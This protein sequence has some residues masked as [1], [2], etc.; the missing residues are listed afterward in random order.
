VAHAN[1]YIFI[2]GHAKS[3]VV[4]ALLTIPAAASAAFLLRVESAWGVTSSTRTQTTS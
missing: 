3:A 1:V 2:I 4:D